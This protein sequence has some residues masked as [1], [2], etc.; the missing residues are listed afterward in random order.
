M[1]PICKERSLLKRAKYKYHWYKEM[2]KML[3]NRKRPV[4]DQS[5]ANT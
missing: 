4:S 2:R 5:I 1:K 3:R